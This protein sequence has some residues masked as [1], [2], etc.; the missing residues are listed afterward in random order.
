MRCCGEHTLCARSL[1]LLW[2]LLFYLVRVS[3]SFFF[4]SAA[5]SVPAGA[6][7][8][9]FCHGWAVCQKDGRRE[10]LRE[11][12]LS[13]EFRGVFLLFSALFFC[14]CGVFG[15]CRGWAWRWAWGRAW[16][17]RRVGVGAQGRGRVG[18]YGCMD[19]C[20]V[21]R[22]AVAGRDASYHLAVGGVCGPVDSVFHSDIVVVRSSVNVTMGHQIVVHGSLWYKQSLLRSTGH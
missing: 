18:A 2:S 5:P 13:V 10:L 22:S 1:T 20:T 11:D 9:M 14:F 19:G 17:C 6:M 4:F 16:G 15:G 21:G 8:V 12:T 3:I 7:S